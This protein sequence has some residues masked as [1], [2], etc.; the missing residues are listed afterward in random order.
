MKK[1]PNDRDLLKIF[2]DD[3]H[4]YSLVG[5]GL[6]VNVVDLGQRPQMSTMDNLIIV[7]Q[8]WRAG[9]KDVTWGKIEEICEDHK[10]DLGR[11][12]YNL[13]EY[14]SSQE[15]HKEYSKKPDKY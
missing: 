8:R 10:D 7:F 15:A 6:A 2:K 11:V 1:E 3:G 4:Q 9:N 12:Q 5:T 13:R 14:L